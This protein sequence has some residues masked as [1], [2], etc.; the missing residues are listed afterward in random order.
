[1]IEVIT[2]KNRA[3][4]LHRKTRTMLKSN[5]FWALLVVG[6]T[7]AL[8]GETIG[9]T[10]PGKAGFLGE[11][12]KKS[13]VGS[14]QEL[15]RF[16]SDVPLSQ[17]RSVTTFHDDGTIIASGQGFVIYNTDLTKAMVES[18]GIGAWVQIDWRTF[19]YT[20]FAVLSDLNGNL[21]GFFKVRGVYQ[22]NS[23]GD[24]YSGHS[25]Y[26][27]LG[28]DYKNNGP[29]GWVCNDGLRIT[30]EAPPKEMPPPC[31]PAE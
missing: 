6:M 14:W 22:L 20:V 21:T 1:M 25:Y 12:K 31:V 28:P 11:F 16:P 2:E 15:V 8:S 24:N 7:A 3:K 30:F 29:Q 9:Q 19:G 5:T 27:F 26:E 10:L 23:S 18:D 4:L 17:Q 13:I